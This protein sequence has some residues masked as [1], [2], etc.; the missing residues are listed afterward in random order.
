LIEKSHPSVKIQVEQTRDDSVIQPGELLTDLLVQIDSFIDG[1]NVVD[2]SW[3][4]LIPVITDKQELTG[5]KVFEDERVIV[6]EK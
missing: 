1:L 3:I 5:Q 2:S 6:Y 4:P